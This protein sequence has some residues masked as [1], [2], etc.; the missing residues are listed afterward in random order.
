M[1]FVVQKRKF[2]VFTSCF[3]KIS[4]HYEPTSLGVLLRE[5][6]THVTASKNCRCSFWAQRMLLCLQRGFLR[7][8]HQIFHVRTRIC[9]SLTRYS[10]SG[11]WID[12]FLDSGVIFK[13]IM[14][15]KIF[16][17]F[18]RVSKL[19]E[20]SC[21]I[22]SILTPVLYVGSAVQIFFGGSIFFVSGENFRSLGWFLSRFFGIQWVCFFLVR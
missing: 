19:L 15:F 22:F 6:E 1:C 18:P 3:Q 14:S 5:S 16:R 13:I 10:E 4:S 2:Q 7:V 9:H 12:I 17:I 8:P 11:N 21:Q 20:K